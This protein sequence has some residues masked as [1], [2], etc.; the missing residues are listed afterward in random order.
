MST[1]FMKKVRDF[2]IFFTTSIRPVENSQ[3]YTV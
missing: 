2:S 3:C 1:L